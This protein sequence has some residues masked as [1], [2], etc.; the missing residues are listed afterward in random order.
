MSDDFFNI[1]KTTG[2]ST[3]GH[4]PGIGD[5]SATA[6]LELAVYARPSTTTPGLPSLQPRMLWRTAVVAEGSWRRAR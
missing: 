5:N 6:P 1:T 2:L 3:E 4:T